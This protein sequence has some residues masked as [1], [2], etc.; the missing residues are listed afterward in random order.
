VRVFT[1]PP[2][3]WIYYPYLI[4]SAAD[5]GSYDYVRRDLEEVVV[6]A[7]VHKVFRERGLKEYPGG[8]RYWVDSRVVPLYDYARRVVRGRVYAVVP[9]YPSD[10]PN[11][12]IRN[13]VEL[14]IRNIQY[15]LDNYREVNWIVPVQGRPGSATSVAST[16]GK[17]RELGL[18]R[19]YVAVA[20]TCVTRSTTFLVRLSLVA[21]Q[22]L[23][24]HRIHMFGV[25]MRAWGAISRYV[26]SVDTVASNWYCRATL[27]RMCTS[28]EEHVAGWASFLRRLAEGGYVTGEVYGRSLDSLRGF[29]SRGGP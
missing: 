18:L 17:L 25:T 28:L 12:P 23:R 7:G 22:L 8:F 24:G 13:N 29:L 15:A 9:D 26:D 5:P 1:R 2:Y 11:N 16:I 19:E 20:P 27:G 10:Y 14:T 21:R 3:P 6:D 4:L